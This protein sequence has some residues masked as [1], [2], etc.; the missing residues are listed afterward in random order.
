MIAPSENLLAIVSD[1]I[2]DT[3]IL[4]Q[5]IYCISVETEIKESGII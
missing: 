3:V 4:Q 5:P 2:K 1:K